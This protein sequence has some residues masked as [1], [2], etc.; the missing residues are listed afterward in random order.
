MRLGARWLVGETP[1]HAVPVALHEVI[2]EQE[3]NHPGAQ[4]W[5]LT[6]LEGRPRCQLDELLVVTLDGVSEEPAAGNGDDD[7][8][9][10]LS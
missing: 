10:W 6:W 4:A 2:A 7:N 9:D 5:T 1:H 3:R 8:D